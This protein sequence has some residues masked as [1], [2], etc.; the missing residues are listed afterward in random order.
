M[1][2]KAIFNNFEGKK[3]KG[4]RMMELRQLNTFRTV[5]TTLNFSRVM[6]VLN[7]VPPTSRCK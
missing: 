2:F 4:D 3:V 6:E 7:Y 1:D 5:A